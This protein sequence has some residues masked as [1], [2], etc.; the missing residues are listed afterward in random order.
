MAFGTH[1]FIPFFDVTIAIEKLISGVQ[2]FLFVLVKLL[3]VC[4][5]L[6][7]FTCLH[8]NWHKKII[9]HFFWRADLMLS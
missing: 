5:I 8:T 9:W 7:F 2:S 3:M 4:A 6:L 1:P